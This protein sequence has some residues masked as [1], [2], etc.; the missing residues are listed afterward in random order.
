M[1]NPF[2]VF[3]GQLHHALPRGHLEA[4]LAALG[5]PLPDVGLYMVFWGQVL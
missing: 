1:Q 5:I 2:K 3:I 4:E